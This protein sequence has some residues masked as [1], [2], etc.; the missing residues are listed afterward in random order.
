VKVVFAVA[1]KAAVFCLLAG[2]RR[3]LNGRRGRGK[4]GHPLREK[5]LELDGD[6][7]RPA[8]GPVLDRFNRCRMLRESAGVRSVTTTPA[9]SGLET[10]KHPPYA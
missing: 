10:K 7:T 6:E 8:R 5:M 4:L 1:L 2:I 3:R 9:R